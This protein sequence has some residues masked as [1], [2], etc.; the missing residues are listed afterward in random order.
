MH[1]S[2]LSIAS[3]LVFLASGSLACGET[4]ETV[5]A[6]EMRLMSAICAFI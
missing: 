3:L 2:D 5:V 6:I 4:V 1:W